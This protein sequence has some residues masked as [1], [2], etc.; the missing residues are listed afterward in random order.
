MIRLFTNDTELELPSTVV[1]ALSKR[2]ANI[3]DFKTR[4]ASF[5]NKFSI[6]LS[7]RNRKALGLEQ[8]NTSNRNVYKDL[9][10]T[11]VSDGIELTANSRL[12]INQ[13]SDVAEVELKVLNGNIFDLLKKT[14]LR[15]VDLTDYDHRWNQA[16][17][18]ASKANNNEDAFVYAISQ[19]GIQST[20]TQ[21]AQCKGLIP[22]VFAKFLLE[23]CA[24]RFG[25]T[26]TGSGF[27][28]QIT[29]NTVIPIQRLANS[30]ELIS[31]YLGESVEQSDIAWENNSPGSETHDSLSGWKIVDFTFSTPDI[32]GICNHWQGTEFNS[33]PING[34]EL[35]VPGIYTVRIDYYYKL[36]DRSGDIRGGVALL[37]RSGAVVTNNLNPLFIQQAAESFVEGEFEGSFTFTFTNTTNTDNLPHNRAYFYLGAYIDT[38][39]KIDF[40][41][42]ATV[43]SIDAPV[44]TFN[45]PITLAP[46]LPNW[47]IGKFFKEIANF[48][49]SY[50]DVDEYSKQ[51]IMTKIS[52]VADNKT[53]PLNW[54]E[55]LLASPPPIRR[56]TSSGL[57]KLTTLSYKDSSLYQFSFEVDNN[58]LPDNSDFVESEF[59]ATEQ[60]SVL[61]LNN[62]ASYLNWDGN[63]D[64]TGR[65]KLDDKPRLLLVRLVTGISFSSPN[66]AT[67]PASGFQTVAYVTDGGDLSLT[68]PDIWA[69]Y[70]EPL[71]GG[72]IPDIQ[73]ITGQFLLNVFDIHTFDFKRPVYLSQYGSFYFVNEIKEFTSKNELTEVELVRIG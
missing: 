17:V 14:K 23:R 45:R 34:F 57:G 37:G 35:I 24:N 56:F 1:V 59:N 69:N 12:V 42:K 7:A 22:H 29:E 31:T 44:T 64:N 61:L 36:Y 15:D 3:G 60:S 52:N 40:N 27:T 18:V 43:V 8:Y 2:V 16:S 13:A 48:T 51:I 9:P 62:V 10:V 58:Q 66:Q 21:V 70:Y 26:M 47:D 20:Q 41:I 50:Y 33:V 73:V 19:L 38:V 53:N 6:P 49:G 46:N 63:L 25:Y 55:K 28:D 32:W 30:P 54:S 72:M 65:A 5:T 71:I 4:G 68:W 67:S 39:G 11:L